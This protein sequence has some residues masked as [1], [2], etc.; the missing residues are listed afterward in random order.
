MDDRFPLGRREP[1]DLRH[2]E[3]YPLTAATL[4]DRPTPV[5]LGVNWYQAF[6]R[7]QED[8][9]GLPFGR[10]AYWIGRGTDWGRVRGG[11]AVVLKPRFVED[12]ATWWSFYD[13]GQEGAC[14]GFAAS[15]M[16][17]L[18]NRSRYGARWLYREAQKIDEWPGEAYSGTSV[19]AG[20][21]VLRDAG[22]RRSVAGVLRPVEARHGI[23]ANR[24]ATDV[25]DILACLGD[26]NAGYVTVLNSWGR[27]YPHFVRLPVE[28][29]HR[30]VFAEGGEATVVVDR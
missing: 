29:L 27:A 1:T 28:A 22:H 30:L 23:A 18:L 24:W 8:A 25:E 13:Q 11:H 10:T 20:M 19:R 21:D 3:R 12:P 26:R 2:V 6:D 14:V 17:S 4:P 9:E 16:M 7:P 15:R 5:V